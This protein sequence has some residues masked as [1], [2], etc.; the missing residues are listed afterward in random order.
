MTNEEQ[1]WE[2]VNEALD[3]G[4]DPLAIGPLRDRLQSAP[5]TLRDVERLQVRLAGLSALR[6]TRT[7]RADKPSPVPFL[8]GLAAASLMAFLVPQPDSRRAVLASHANTPLSEVLASSIAV[9][10]IQTEAPN[11]ARVQHQPK[12]VV[13]WKLSGEE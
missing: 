7:A 12:R 1:L 6:P 8:A 9:E 5:E 10:H 2:A 13:V 4:L 11:L 3:T